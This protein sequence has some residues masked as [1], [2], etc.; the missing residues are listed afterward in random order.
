ME[1]AALTEPRVL[2]NAP[3]APAAFLVRFAEGGIELE[4]GVWINDP[5][6]GQL[7]LRSSIQRAIWKF[8]PRE[9]HQD[10][11]SRRATCA[12][13]GPPRPLRAAASAPDRA[14]PAV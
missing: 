5:E 12:W 11:A 2:K 8:V 1:A 3:N 6:K 14:G 7:D 13:P 4:L 10:P 9:R